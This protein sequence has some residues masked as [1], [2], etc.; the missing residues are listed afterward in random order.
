MG[1]SA[2]PWTSKMLDTDQTGGRRALQSFGDSDK[3]S[4]SRQ[5][6]AV[7][8]ARERAKNIHLIAHRVRQLLTRRL[9]PVL[10]CYEG[11]ASGFCACVSTLGQQTTSIDA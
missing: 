8:G 5:P 4:F 11:S 9:L 7:R 2:S 10:S 3:T 6:T 1:K